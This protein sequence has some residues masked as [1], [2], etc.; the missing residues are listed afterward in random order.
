MGGEL[1]TLV[2]VVLKA[3]NLK[4]KHSFY[5]QDVYA[6]IT[7]NGI[8]KKTAVEVKGGQHPVWD[9]EL[10]FPI[11]TDTSEKARTLHG[12]C[13]S[14]EPRGDESVGEGELDISETLKTGE[15]D[16]E[17]SKDIQLAETADILFL[18]D[19]VP[20]KV[21]GTYRGDLYLEMTF[22]AAGPPPALTRRP[23]KMKPSERLKRPD[24]AYAYPVTSPPHEN[25]SLP[26]T[27]H[28]QRHDPRNAASR[29]VSPHYK[30]DALPPLPEE[31]TAATA[32]SVPSILRPGKPN[33]SPSPGRG[34]GAVQQPL[35]SNFS[36]GHSRNPS[37]TP[38][39]QG[40]SPPK[41]LMPALPQALQASSPRHSIS[42]GAGASDLPPSLQHGRPPRPQSQLYDRPHQNHSQPP[43]NAYPPNSNLTPTPA[44]APV[45]TPTPYEYSNSNSNHTQEPVSSFSFPTP[46]ASI[47]SPPASES[48]YNPPQPSIPAYNPPPASIP[49]YNPPPSNVPTYSYP[50]PQ[51]PYFPP[52]PQFSTGPPVSH[53]SQ[54]QA[55]PPQQ[56]PARPYSYYG[57]PPPQESN[58]D[59]PDPF[60]MERYKTPLPLPDE[61]L[62]AYSSK[63]THKHS[64][65][66]SEAGS[67]ASHK[68]DKARSD[69]AKKKK[70]EEDKAL[71]LAMER[72]EEERK[73][74]LREQEEIDLEIAR[75]L[76]MELNL[77]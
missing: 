71:A 75:K 31:A 77:D 32:A 68:T 74:R 16:G 76:D 4:D 13:W 66:A 51:A 37:L 72:E 8:T 52:V 22:Y 25:S 7:I 10:R 20:L 59:L 47:Y 48:P 60:K 46:D 50:P 18:A 12:S 3:R 6:Q 5:K 14:V 1:G 70:D 19:W 21:D 55:Y 42:V 29:S 11:S 56:A 27:G 2:V 53:F 41:S 65:S 73:R 35:P 36:P 44:P 15:F 24:K 58:F 62:G 30:R 45:P 17:D 33:K 28:P 40:H 26:A 49:Q 34:P 43:Y 23:T 39:S 63:R 69:A 61:P 54:A 57:P 67:S 9:E 64:T 38:P